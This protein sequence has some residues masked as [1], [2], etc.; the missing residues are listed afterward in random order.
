MTGV[1]FLLILLMLQL[2]AA[3]AAWAA[4][5]PAAGWTSDDAA[6]A[7][8]AL[9]KASSVRTLTVDLS[10][11]KMARFLKRHYEISGMTAD[12]YP[13]L[14]KLM[15]TQAQVHALKGVAGPRTVALSGD[16]T[17]QDLATLM[18]GV[19]PTSGQIYQ[20]A[21]VASMEAPSADQRT[22]QIAYSSLCFYDVNN[23]PI[24]T[25]ATQSSFG[26]GQYFP[27]NNTL[28]AAPEAFTAA[29][30]ATYY[31]VTDKRYVSQISTLT[32][33]ATEYPSSQTITDP[34]IVHM[35]QNQGYARALVC[36][37]RAVNANANPGG[38]CDY[39][40]YQN[41]NVL[42]AMGGSVIYASN[43]SPQ[44]DGNNK[45]VGTG[46]ISLI[47][48]DSG[49]QC[50]VAAPISGSSFFSQPTVTYVTATKTL[51]WS[52]T[53]LDFGPATGLICGT[54]AT[55][56]QFSL[57]LQVTDTDGA[58]NPIV[59]SQYSQAG[60][61]VPQLAG[62]NAGA[63]L[64]PM[65]R[66]VAGC[67]HPDTL[68]TLANGKTVAISKITGE[69]EVLRGKGGSPVPVVGTVKGKDA[70]LY[71]VR[72][73]GGLEIKA[74]ANHPFVDAKGGWRAA[75]TL[76]AGDS[77][78][79]AKG[80]AKVLSVTKV[81]YG[82]EVDNLVLGHPPETF[83]VANEAFYANGFLVGGH[84]AQQRVAAARR[85]ENRNVLSLLPADF[86]VDYANH[87]KRTAQH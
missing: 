71:V 4:P 59:A 48:T 47:N 41:N 66:M 65:L 55:N 6:A 43:Q 36:T 14:H 10:D 76:K 79:T 18:L 83:T 31:D 57:T 34:V 17:Y 20:G 50:Q 53:N 29:F 73:A 2:G 49:G 38:I 51:S 56:I 54:T 60:I 11:P 8:Y 26:S 78:L 80:A 25:C 39:G 63:L 74:T 1:R 68:V 61:T 85:S 37:N 12:L 84:D 30:T 81:A 33:D 67:L 44:L 32:A 13:G 24:G 77:L 23:N 5:A 72:A 3:G 15:A 58:P 75:E 9:K 35:Q 45:P 19:F 87:L 82:G 27:V 52:F 86:K 46:S 42:V 62:P 22:L 69:G 40:T 16:M 70:W 28:T 7:G 64:T 21:A